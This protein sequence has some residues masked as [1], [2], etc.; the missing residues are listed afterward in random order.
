M[1]RESLSDPKT[2]NIWRGQNTVGKIAR[3]LAFARGLWHS[4]EMTDKKP[5][6]PRAAG[7]FIALGLI[8][9]A[10]IGVVL[11]QP[12]LGVL[13]GLAAGV[14]VALVHWRMDRRA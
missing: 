11:R 2:V 6:A 7:A 1:T 3:H 13:L 10:L 14:L 4:F 12:S 5:P 8:G 9:G